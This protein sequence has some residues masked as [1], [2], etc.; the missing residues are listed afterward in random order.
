VTALDRELARALVAAIRDDPD[1]RDELRGLLVDTTAEPTPASR[2]WLTVAEA[3]ERL[4]CT[5]DAVRMRCSRGR[6]DHRRQGR[7]LYVSADSVD[8]LA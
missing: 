7:R 5:P 8:R 3:A 4:A 1:L 2:K 6:L